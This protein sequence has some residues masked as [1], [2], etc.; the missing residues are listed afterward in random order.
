MY[1]DRNCFSEKNH[2]SIPDNI[3]FNAKNYIYF[4]YLKWTSLWQVKLIIKLIMIKYDH[5]KY[6][7]GNYPYEE[8]F[9]LQNSQRQNLGVTIIHLFML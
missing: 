2:N 9:V 4:Y 6:F 5:E 3:V 8:N 7:L 1:R